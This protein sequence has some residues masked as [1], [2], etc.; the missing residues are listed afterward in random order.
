MKLKVFGIFL[1]LIAPS[2]TFS[3]E[4]CLLDKVT[5]ENMTTSQSRV[6]SAQGAE[7]VAQNAC[8]NAD[9]NCFGGIKRQAN[10]GD[11]YQILTTTEDYQKYRFEDTNDVRMSS[12]KG[13]RLL[14]LGATLIEFETSWFSDY[15]A[16]FAWKGN[17]VECQFLDKGDTITKQLLDAPLGGE[18]NVSG[19]F[20]SGIDEVNLQ[21]CRL[22]IW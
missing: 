21:K 20:T 5:F 2:Q 15:Y 8:F 18:Y 6:L 4:R 10:A 3:A 14:F 19:A 12:L 16:E 22:D 11:S 13:T 1:L 9:S 7:C 17:I